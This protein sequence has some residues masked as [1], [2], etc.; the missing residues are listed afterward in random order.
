MR[1]K[2]IHSLPSSPSAAKWQLEHGEHDEATVGEEASSSAQKM[3]ALLR[4]RHTREVPTSSQ[5]L[6]EIEQLFGDDEHEALGFNS[7]SQ[8]IRHMVKDLHVVKL[9]LAHGATR[10]MG[11]PRKLPVPR[12]EGSTTEGGELGAQDSQHPP[13][14]PR[15]RPNDS[16]LRAQ[17]RTSQDKPSLDSNGQ[18]S[19][20]VNRATS[21]FAGRK[22]HGRSARPADNQS[23]P[24]SPIAQAEAVRGEI[25][26]LSPA[27]TRVR[28][29]VP[30]DNKYGDA[31]S[32]NAS[33]VKM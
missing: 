23:I 30:N 12:G 14:S 8:A 7:D 17:N 25:G 21:R 13:Q 18:L 2:S 28:V 3:E 31:T 27:R 10:H 5:L 9:I 33:P 6:R 24:I 4:S 20:S 15:N 16:A 19:K 1:R 22:A 32:S 11:A 29:R 26:G